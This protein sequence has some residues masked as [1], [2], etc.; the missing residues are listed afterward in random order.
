MRGGTNGNLSSLVELLYAFTM[1]GI[2]KRYTLLTF[3]FVSWVLFPLCI[4]SFAD[5]DAKEYTEVCDLVYEWSP[6]GN[7]IQVGDYTISK[8]GSVWLERGNEDLVRAGNSVIKQGGLVKALLVNKDENGFWLADKIIVFSGS[9]LDAAIE[10]L[11]ES[12]RKQ[13]LES[14]ES[15]GKSRAP[16]YQSQQP[17]LEEGV[18]KN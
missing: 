9:A 4:V 8:I 12:K 16:H 2:M 14:M 7:A 5:E 13:L 15:E 11:P 3:L 6:Q 1:R 18:W 10:K 17:F